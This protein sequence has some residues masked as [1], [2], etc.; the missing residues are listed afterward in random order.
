MLKSDTSGLIP[1]PKSFVAIA[2][3]A[4]KATAVAPGMGCGCGC[5]RASVRAIRQTWNAFTILIHRF[6]AGVVK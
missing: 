6:V 5:S 1:V 3:V 2:R 4:T